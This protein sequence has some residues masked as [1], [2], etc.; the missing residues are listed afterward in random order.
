GYAC[1]LVRE[2]SA[3]PPLPVRLALRRA[4]SRVTQNVVWHLGPQQAEFQAVVQL[5]ADDVGLA[6]LEFEILSPSQQP[7]T[8]ASVAARGRPAGPRRPPLE[9]ERQPPADLAGGHDQPGAGRGQGLGDAAA[10]AAAIAVFARAVGP[11]APQP[12]PPH[13]RPGVRGAPEQ[14]QQPD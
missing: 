13:R 4:T 11:R 14:P 6:V 1:A 2:G 12:D 10:G 7:V 5:K 3:A 9:P 8:V